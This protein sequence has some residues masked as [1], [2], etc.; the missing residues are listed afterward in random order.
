M[1]KWS[2]GSYNHFLNES[3][4]RYGLTRKEAAQVYREIRARESKPVFK[5]YLNK[6]PRIAGKAAKQAQRIV[7]DK[8]QEAE[9]QEQFEREGELRELELL[10]EAIRDG[11]ETEEEEYGD[12]FD[13]GKSQ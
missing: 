11:E 7:A 12:G 6:H 13:T 10:E 9:E 1:A 4:K 8:E 3:I 2:L 5:S